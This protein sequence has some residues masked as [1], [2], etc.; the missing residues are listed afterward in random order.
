[1]STEAPKQR[2]KGKQFNKV[3]EEAIS[4]GM[5][6]ERIK[7][8][9][10]AKR[11]RGTGVTKSSTKGSKGKVK[12]AKVTKLGKKGPQKSNRLFKNFNSLFTSNVYTD[13]NRNS[14]I[15]LPTS[16]QKDKRKAL[17][18]IV[19]A[20]PLADKR[21]VT[22]D[23]NAL[24]LASKTLGPRQCRRDTSGNWKFNGMRSLL[25]P[26]QVYPYLCIHVTAVY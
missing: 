20:I 16:T 6:E 19:A 7:E 1:M 10:K 9:R 5:E 14:G 24:I 23:A 13:G 18:E 22:Q 2:R 4:A 17:N 15:T 3:S 11:G 8:M 26:H 21:I 12:E 25:R